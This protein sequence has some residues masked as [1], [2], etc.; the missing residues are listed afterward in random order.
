MPSRIFLTVGLGLGED[1]LHLRGD[2]GPLRLVLGLCLALVGDELGQRRALGALHA[3]HAGL[4]LRG[5]LGLAL[6]DDVLLLL[7]ELPRCGVG[8]R[9]RLLLI[10]KRLLEIRLVG[11]RQLFLGDL[12]VGHLLVRLLLAGLEVELLGRRRFGYGTRGRDRRSGPL[13]LGPHRRHR[14]RHTPWTCRVAA[15]VAVSMSLAW[16]SLPWVTSPLTSPLT[17]PALPDSA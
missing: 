1:G 3:G 15:A 11:L 17:S 14:L 2:L 13:L 16:P 8:V 6:R 9:R 4:G 5:R 7:A 12:G 10:G